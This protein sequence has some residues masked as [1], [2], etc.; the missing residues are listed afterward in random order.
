M[1]IPLRGLSDSFK[2]ICEEIKFMRD[3]EALREIFLSLINSTKI[4]PRFLMVSSSRADV[5]AA[6]D[7]TMHENAAPYKSMRGKIPYHF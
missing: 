2:E 7:V 4:P 6:M 5:A 1:L 3:L